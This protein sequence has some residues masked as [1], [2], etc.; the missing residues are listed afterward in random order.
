MS[1]DKRLVVARTRI[2]HLY[3]VVS[4]LSTYDGNKQSYGIE[5]DRME[6]PMLKLQEEN[7]AEIHTFPS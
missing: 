3:K 1:V 2:G 5:G 6:Q 4:T 7:I